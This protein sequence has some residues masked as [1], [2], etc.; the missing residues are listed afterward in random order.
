MPTA[1]AA[2]R[3]WRTAVTLARLLP[4]YVLASALRHVV[5]LNRLARWAWREPVARSGGG[6]PQRLAAAV[7]RLGQL[8]PGDRN[9]LRRSLVLYRE[10]SARGADPRLVVGFRRGS[11]GVEGHAW[12]TTADGVVGDDAVHVA[13]FTPT[14]RFGRAGRAEP[15][16]PTTPAV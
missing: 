9:C 15:I 12:V 14:C 1:S 3:R 13:T 4:S 6:D 10:L 11:L 8:V 16:D 5:P 2:P 7:T